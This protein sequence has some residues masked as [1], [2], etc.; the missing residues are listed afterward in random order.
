MTRHKKLRS[1]INE[2]KAKCDRNPKGR[3]TKSALETQRR[4]Q[5]S[6]PLD[7]GLNKNEALTGEKTARANAQSQE[8]TERVWRTGTV[9]VWVD[10]A[11]TKNRLG[12]GSGIP[13]QLGGCPSGKEEESEIIRSDSWRETRIVTGKSF[14]FK[15]RREAGR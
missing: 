4:L 5:R 6:W 1:I 7:C 14:F 3:T 8:G 9:V 2:V 12:S 15:L 11:G 10:K 13:W